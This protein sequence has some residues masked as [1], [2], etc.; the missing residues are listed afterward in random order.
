MADVLSKEDTEP[1]WDSKWRRV[2]DPKKPRFTLGTKPGL[3]RAQKEQI[4]KSKIVDPKFEAYLKSEAK[5]M[6][7]EKKAKD[8][9]FK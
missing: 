4:R 9:L 6:E 8:A 1:W 5:R 2:Q 3:T 7:A